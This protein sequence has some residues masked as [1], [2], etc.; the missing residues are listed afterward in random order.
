MNQTTELEEEPF[1]MEST[2]EWF[3]EEEAEGEFES[4]D[5]FFGEFDHEDGTSHCTCPP[6]PTAARPSAL[7]AR[8]PSLG[9]RR[10]RPPLSSRDLHQ[11]IQR[12][13]AHEANFNKAI[14]AL[15]RYIVKRN[16][17]YQFTLPA[18]S[19]REVASKLGLAPEMVHLLLGSLKHRNA[20][21]RAA[22]AVRELEME[23][24]EPTCAGKKGYNPEWYGLRVWW[25]ECRTQKV[26]NLLKSGAKIGSSVLC[27]A[28]KGSI[29]FGT[30]LVGKAAEEIFG[31]ACEEL[32]EYLLENQ[33]PAEWLEQRDKEGGNQGVVIKIAVKGGEAYRD[34]ILAK[35][36]RIAIY[37]QQF[38]IWSPSAKKWVWVDS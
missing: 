6:R 1:E 35:L 28:L 18:R 37:P 16:G 25:D 36:P 10:P 3:G 20:R 21:L 17:F 14:A 23:M 8:P 9:P 5:E 22:R 13:P 2:P 30:D 33:N 26:I 11:H 32:A 38:Q 31:L 24:E 4:S 29:A 34:P 27:E 12:H 7:T 19:V 15:N